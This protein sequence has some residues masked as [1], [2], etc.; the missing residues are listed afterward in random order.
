MGS[1]GSAVEMMFA[2]VDDGG[3][4]EVSAA[5]AAPKGRRLNC[6]NQHQLRMNRSIMDSAGPAGG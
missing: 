5:L 6:K 4:A 3:V 1:W 2:A